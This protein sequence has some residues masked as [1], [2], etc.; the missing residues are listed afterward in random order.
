MEKSY[1]KASEHLL[2][3]CRIYGGWQGLEKKFP[4]ISY[5]TLW[6]VAH[7]LPVTMETALKISRISKIPVEGFRIKQDRNEF[8]KIREW[9]DALRAK[10]G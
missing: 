3:L 1:K 6:R 2:E 8:S 4:G 9:R 7:D 10:R 5:K